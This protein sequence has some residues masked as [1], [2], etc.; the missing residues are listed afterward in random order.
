MLKENRGVKKIPFTKKKPGVKKYN[1]LKEPGVKKIQFTKET[2]RPKVFG[3]GYFGKKYFW[4]RKNSFCKKGFFGKKL[5]L[6]KKSFW[7]KTFL[8]QKDF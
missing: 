4:A 8:A 1:L 7:P 3:Q 5:F 2:G 6:A